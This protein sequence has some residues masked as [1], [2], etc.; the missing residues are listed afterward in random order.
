MSQPIA[1]DFGLVWSGFGVWD[2][3][4]K[5]KKRR[6]RRWVVWDER[7]KIKKKN[8]RQTHSKKKKHPKAFTP[9][10]C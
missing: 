9:F 2:V 1:F 5:K 3:R 8:R 10:V 7:N 4:N 6:R